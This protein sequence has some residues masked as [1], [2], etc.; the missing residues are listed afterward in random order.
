MEQSWSAIEEKWQTKWREAK[1]FEADPSDKPKV[2]VT[3]PYAYLNGPLHLGHA[4]TCLKVDIYAR[5]KRMQGYNVL[6][7][8]A[9]HATGEPIAGVAERVRKNDEKQIKILIESGVPPHDIKKFSDPE[10]IVEYYRVDGVKAFNRIGFSIDWRRQ[11]TTITREYNKFI[12]WQ[13]YT[14]KDKGYVQKGT[15][16]V[17]WCPSC[18]SPTGDHDRLI[19]EGVSPIDYILLKFKFE[20]SWLVMATLRPETIFGVVNVWVNPD[21][22]YV[23]AEVNGEKWVMSKEAVI[24]FIEQKKRVKVIEE[25][26]GVKLLGKYCIV[27]LTNRRVPIL[28]AYFVDPN[29][30]SGVVMSV[31]SHAPYDWLG[32][33]DLKNNPSLL[34]KYGLN[35]KILEGI[36]PI[37]LI[38]TPGLGEHPA[39]D[40]VAEMKIKDQKDPK[41]EE[42]TKIIYKK[43]FHQG[44]LRE[45]TGKY[46]G[47]PVRDI[48]E[49]LTADLIN[50]NIADIMWE[51]ADRVIC[52]CN[53]PCIVKILEDQWFLTYSDPEW[54]KIAHEVLDNAIVLPAEAKTSFE[55]TIDWLT[56]KACARRTGLGTKLPWD[57]EWIVETLSDSTIYMAF[58]TIAKYINDGRIKAEYLTRE[59][60]DYVFLSKGDP[61]KLSETLK[62]DKEIIEEVKKE[63]EYWYPVDLRN[64]AKELVYNHFTFFL[65]HHGAIFPKKHWPRILGVNGMI[66]IEGQKMSKSK[67]IFISINDAVTKF[68][69]DPT[70][71]ELAYASEG[72]ADA[73]WRTADV[74]GLRNKIISVFHMLKNI[75]DNL[76]ERVELVDKWLES[77]VNLAIKKTTEHYERLENRSAIQEAFFNLQNDLKWYLRRKIK[78]SSVFRKAAE[79]MVKLVAPVIPHFSEELWS[80]WGKTGFISLEKWPEC[81]EDKINE[82]YN[83]WE[84]YLQTLLADIREIIKVNK[85]SNPTKIKFFIAHQWK[86]EIYSEAQ[87]KPANLFETIMKQEKYRKYGKDVVNYLKKL[88]RTSIIQ[89]K[90]DRE[91]EIAVLNDAAWFI[92]KELG[93]ETVEIISQNAEEHPKSKIAEPLK[94]GILIE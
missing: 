65:F 85:L 30:A 21:A 20:D 51:T 37:S 66:N 47:I 13:Y 19:G 80:C 15:H 44:V 50:N 69:A 78:P 6:F 2:F 90:I 58:Y 59:F 74:I 84:E 83:V 11:F 81:E 23:K 62:L 72:L 46:S 7:P 45:N 39:V 54:K 49:K 10:Y 3:F 33:L 82:E 68:G 5:F 52:R 79:V 8:F 71:L 25:F 91:K 53:T 22:D 55:Y 57:K 9:F 31:P 32:L 87:K 75:D 35:S 34:E 61:D 29:N 77:R 73:D 4:Y 40:I 18:R 24:K 56:D 36:K 1:I 93:V 42:A 38:K 48:K 43:E 12:E 41:A 27:P 88:Q 26:K 67:G 60:F 94:P 92:K 28:P 70:R 17:V 64:S 86:Y 16:P 63:F 14:L 76:D 89:V